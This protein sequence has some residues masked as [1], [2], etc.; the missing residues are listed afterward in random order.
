MA[1]PGILKQIAGSNPM[2]GSIKQ[3]FGMVQSAQNPQA[4]LNQ[5]ASSNPMMK[6]AMDLINASGGDAMKAFYTLAAEKGVDPQEILD[7]LK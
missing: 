4:M 1:L 2:L 6:Q 5:L 7:M 3:M